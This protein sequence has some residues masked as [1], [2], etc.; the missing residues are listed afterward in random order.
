[1]ASLDDIKQQKSALLLDLQTVKQ[2]G[3][4]REVISLASRAASLEGHLAYEFR[5]L[6]RTEDACISYISQASC[7]VDASRLIEA[8]RVF[9]VAAALASNDTE[10]SDWVRSQL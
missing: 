10:L 5:K 8:H 9:E 3:K 6:G 4:R 1:M 7:Y 2:Q